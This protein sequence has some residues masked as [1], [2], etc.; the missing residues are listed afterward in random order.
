V[1]ARRRRRIA[2][3][4]RPVVGERGAV[5]VFTAITMVA[6]LAFLG[7]ALDTARGYVTRARLS[8]AVDA[9]ALGGARALRQ[10]QN[11]AT[12]RAQALAAANGVSASGGASL[13]ISFGVNA[14]QENTVHVSASQ[15][16]PTLFMRILDHN[17]MTVGSQALA[18]VPP[19]DIA[20]V[21]DQS[22][23]LATEG[24]CDDMQDAARNF[25]D[26]FSDEIDQMGLV[27][28]QVM[29]AN[30]FMLNKPFRSSVKS[31]IGQISCV[32]DTN[33]REGL[34]FGYNQLKLP[35]VRP[36][37]AKVLVF[38]TDGRPTAFRGTVSGQDRLVAVYTTISNRVRGYFNTPDSWPI[39]QVANPPSGCKDVTSCFGMNENA[40]RTRA[41]TD[42]LAMAQ[43]ARQ[44]G[45][46]I[47]SIGLGN[48]NNPN[49][50]LVPD[51]D[52]LRQIANESGV[53]SG[54][55]PQGK[56]YFAPTGAQLDGVFQ[57]VADQILVRLAE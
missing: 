10:G 19:L 40:V 6:L 1:F 14:E 3:L 34:R 15:T 30:H 54:S 17:S 7:L 36:R 49:P 45:F 44:D 28:F 33:S 23:S 37:A 53:V 9:A 56:A 21:L 52:F 32:G 12:A 50:I 31:K 48:P 39:N 38:F 43:T 11:V 22:G 47:Y 4:L 2:R 51:M 24:V 25:V 41:R 42:A 20:F 27:S 26:R 35:N 46:V 13:S 5:L 18:A 55:Q 16:V 8:R 57:E 29:A